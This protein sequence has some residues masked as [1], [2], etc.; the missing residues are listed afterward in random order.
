[1]SLE[2]IHTYSLIHDDLPPMDDDDLRRGKPTN[3]KVFGE[4][5]AI[6]A[7]DGLLTAAFQLLSL[8]QL[9]LSEKVL[10]MQK[11]AKAARNQ[12]MLAG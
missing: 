7:G 9:G 1:A 8:S 10:L 6:L 12:G 11:L 4:A 3:H 2:M 5:T